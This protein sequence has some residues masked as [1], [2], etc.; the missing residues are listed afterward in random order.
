LIAKSNGGSAPKN[1]ASKTTRTGGFKSKAPRGTIFEIFK[2]KMPAMACPICQK[3]ADAKYRPFCCKR[4]ADIDLGK[5]FDGTYTVAGDED[6][7]LAQ[8][9]DTTR[10]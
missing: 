2:R 4:C 9:D 8:D 5:W 7:P 3:T 6:A 1:R 10:H